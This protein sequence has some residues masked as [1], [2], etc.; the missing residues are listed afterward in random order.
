MA[1]DK[2]EIHFFNVGQGNSICVECFPSGAKSKPEYVLIDCFSLSRAK[3]EPP[4]L[5]FLKSKK[6]DRL[7]GIILT[8][9]D[10]DH[11][12]GLSK[13]LEYFAQPGR[14]IDKFIYLVDI[15]FAKYNFTDS[16]AATTCVRE[17]L[18]KI[19][20]L[21]A[22]LK[23]PNLTVA[24]V[25]WNKELLFSDLEIQFLYP[26]QGGF[27]RFQEWVLSELESKGAQRIN[28][29]YTTLVFLLRFGSARFFVGGDLIGGS[30]IHK[31]GI[32]LQSDVVS[33]PHHGSNE[34]DKKLWKK[35][36]KPATSATKPTYA[37]ISSGVKNLY[38]HPHKNVINSI[39]NSG[40]DLYCINKAPS[41]ETTSM[42]GKNLNKFVRA[43][44]R[45]GQKNPKI[46]DYLDALGVP[47]EGTC[48]GDISVELLNTG[49]AKIS[50]R[51]QNASCVV[52]E[53]WK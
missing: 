39:I 23:I 31:G 44:L 8:H 35:L 11:F 37:I 52:K 19:E 49:Q 13:V 21:L 22:S 53:K 12:L 41:C 34:V 20:T 50:K 10:V 9:L 28:W 27:K 7:K 47:K 6:V 2:V 24:T 42:V 17:E 25:A 48:S 1:I 43:N 5:N 4:V 45:L 36:A 26:Q 40:M 3:P 32:P 33:V 51:S 16:G 15:R 18:K 38:R 46:T 29:N 30:S 14:G